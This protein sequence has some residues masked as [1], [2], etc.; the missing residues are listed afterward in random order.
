M[1]PK[2]I[3]TLRE[4]MGLTQQAFADIIGCQQHM[5]SHWERGKHSPRGAYLKALKELAEKARKKRKA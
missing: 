1:S 2:Q 4:A 3:R 5:V